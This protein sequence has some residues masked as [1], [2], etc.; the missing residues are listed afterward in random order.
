MTDKL[1]SNRQARTYKFSSADCPVV[2]G[3]RV[4]QDLSLD[5]ARSLRWL[6]VKLRRCPQCAAAEGCPILKYFHE[7]VNAAVQ[8]VNDEWEQL[9]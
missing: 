5:M 3:T 1:P 4:V 6:R 9:G 8:M 2:G 7:Q